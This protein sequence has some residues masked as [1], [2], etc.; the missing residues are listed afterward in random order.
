MVGILRISCPLP[1]AILTNNCLKSR[2]MHRVTTMLASFKVNT[3]DGIV[4]D[5]HQDDQN[6]TLR[7]S[8]G[9]LVVP[10]A[11]QPDLYRI[12]GLLPGIMIMATSKRATNS[13]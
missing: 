13:S 11:G 7:T 8:E 6:G 3:Q 4:F 5:V 12:T 9:Y 10:V 2:Q 1:R